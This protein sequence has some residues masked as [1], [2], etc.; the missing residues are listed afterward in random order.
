MKMLLDQ[1]IVPSGAVKLV[2]EE[3][4]LGQL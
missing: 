1:I 3:I 2:K 4:K